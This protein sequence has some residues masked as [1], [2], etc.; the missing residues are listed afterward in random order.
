MLYRPAPHRKRV[1]IGSP[2]MVTP[3]ATTASR[4]AS[5]AGP[6]LFGPLVERSMALRSPAVSIAL[7]QIL[8]KQE[9]TRI[10]KC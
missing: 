8:R 9:R 2:L 7:E 6:R 3:S 10:W 4:A 5:T 1:M